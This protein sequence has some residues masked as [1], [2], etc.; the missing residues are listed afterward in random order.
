M[1]GIL[2]TALA[3]PATKLQVLNRA[4]I[5]RNA[6]HRARGTPQRIH[7][8]GHVGAL[9]AR[10]EHHKYA[11]GIQ[12]AVASASDEGCDIGHI[13]ISAQ[14]GCHAVLQGQHGRKG[15]IF[16]R[17]CRDLQLP[18][19]FFGEKSFGQAYSQQTG[20]HKREQRHKQHQPATQQC[21]VQGAH[22]KPVHC[23]KQSLKSTADPATRRRMPALAM[24]LAF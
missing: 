11:A 7:H 10:L 16:R 24:A 3:L 5:H 15:N 12:R 21:P 19:V 23:I 13:R 17:L 8:V 2:V 1:Q 22:V 20:D 6:G 9:A 4:H 18:D 14:D